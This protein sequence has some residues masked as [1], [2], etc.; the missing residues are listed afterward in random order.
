MHNAQPL[1]LTTLSV[2][3]DWIDYNGHMNVGYYG[4]AFDRAADLFTDRLGF[5]EGYRKRSNCSSYVLETRTG[6]L[7]E[8][9][10]GERVAVDVHLLDFDA[11]RLHYYLRMLHSDDGQVC[12]WTEVM[13]MHMDMSTVSGAPMPA[14]ILD[15]VRELAESHRAISR[16]AQL[17]HGMGIR[18]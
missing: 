17:E 7:R 2:E 5:N 10:L 12:A 9:K 16:P 4:V 8:L 18:R 3:P 14:D 1:T 13:L 15:N 11:K 6:F